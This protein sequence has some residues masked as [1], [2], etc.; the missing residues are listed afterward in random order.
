[1]S[2]AAGFKLFPAAVTPANAKAVDTADLSTLG[3]I[4][5]V[6]NKDCAG[7]ICVNSVKAVV[8]NLPFVVAVS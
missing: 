2:E 6:A 4:H 8:E 3:I 7:A 1:M 5:S